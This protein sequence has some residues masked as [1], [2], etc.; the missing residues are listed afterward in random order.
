MP[1]IL[2][3]PVSGSK[4]S[5]LLSTIYN[6]REHGGEQA[7]TPRG[8]N[9]GPELVQ[10]TWPR[11][12]MRGLSLGKNVLK[13]VSWVELPVPLIPPSKKTMSSPGTC[14]HDPIWEEDIC[15]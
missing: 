6:D 9:R 10:E 13:V 2:A 8:R 1:G 15:R 11:T 3:R 5:V 12:E 4:L 14:E 7:G